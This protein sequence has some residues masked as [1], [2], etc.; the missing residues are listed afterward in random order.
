MN[1]SQPAEKN[2][3]INTSTAQHSMQP[4]AYQGI[5]LNKYMASAPR[6][7]QGI[8]QTEMPQMRIQRFTNDINI[9]SNLN[10]MMPSTYSQVIPSSSAYSGSN[11]IAQS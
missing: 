5:N 3:F 8:V 11:S 4:A 1:S 2:N 6:A 10:Q 9:Q 7:G